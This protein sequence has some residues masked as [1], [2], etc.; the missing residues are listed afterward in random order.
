MSVSRPQ[1]AID[2]PLVV[3]PP[4]PALRQLGR[5]HLYALVAD[6]V[7]TA[8]EAAA[9]DAPDA[10]RSWAPCGLSAVV[11][12]WLAKEPSGRVVGGVEV[13]ENRHSR[14]GFLENLV[15][16]PDFRGHGV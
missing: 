7:Y 8:A 14:F 11:A 6:G 9:L 10:S 1:V 15:V 2:S 12:T 5:A 13:W 16:L 3:G 4:V